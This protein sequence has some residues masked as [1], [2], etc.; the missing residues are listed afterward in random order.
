[1]RSLDLHGR[2]AQ[3]LVKNLCGLACEAGR[4]HAANLTKVTDRNREADR[5]AANKDWFEDRV[6]GSVKTAAI[7]IVVQKHVAL[8]EIVNIDL[9]YAR[10]EEQRHPSDHRRAKIAGRNQFA[11]RQ[12][13]AASE[14]KRLAK[15]GGIGGAHERHTHVAANGDEYASNDV[16]RNHV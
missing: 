10:P 11:A 3:S 12:R 8:L 7:G 14:I 9:I 15:N 1:T 5:F 6:L 16:Q 2:H 13:E 4:R